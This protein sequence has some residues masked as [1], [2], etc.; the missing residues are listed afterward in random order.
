MRTISRLVL[1]WGLLTMPAVVQAVIYAYWDHGDGTCTITGY[2]GSGGDVRIPDMI[3]GLTVTSIGQESFA[4][5]TGLTSVTISNGVTS[6]GLRA[7]ESC[8]NLTAITVSASNPG[9][10]SLDGVL[11]NKKRSTLIQCPGGKTGSYTIPN[12]V[13]NIEGWAFYG[14]ISLTNVVIGNSVTNIGFE[15]FCTCPSLTSVTIGPKVTGIGGWAFL[16]CTALTRLT[17]PNSVISIGDG[18]FEYCTNLTAGYFQG[19]APSLNGSS[20]FTNAPTTI[21]YFPETTGWG[22]TFGGRPTVP[23]GYAYTNNGDGTCAITGYTGNGGDVTIPNTISNLLVT[24]IGNSAF[25]DCTNLTS[26]AIPDSVTN[27]G[28]KAFQYCTRLTNVVTGNNVSNI[29]DSAFD[30]CYSLTGVMIPNSVTNIGFDAFFNCTSLSNVTI[31]DRVISIYLGAF[32]WCTSLMDIDVATSNA[33]Y[34]SVDGVLFDKNLTRLIQYPIGRAGSFTFPSSVTSIE[35][36]A[37]GGSTNL[38]SFTIPDGITQIWPAAF[39]GCHNLVSVTIAAS[40]TEIHGWAFQYCQSL[41]AVYFQGNAPNVNDDAFFYD[42]NATFYYLPGT[43]GWDSMG[44]ISWGESIPIPIVLWNPRAQSDANFGVQ[45]NCFGFTIS[46]STNLVIVT[47]ACTNLA[48]PSWSA[49]GTNTLTGGSSYFS[50]P[51]WTNSPARFYR[52]RSP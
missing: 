1:L 40:V 32:S 22:A 31:P 33:R 8:T 2:L 50:D 13:T 17:I 36:G 45:T 39:A 26:V 34:C 51:G 10:S 29:G 12:S 28:N 42:V 5:K 23:L 46:G 19:N 9:Y 37:F 38:T 21:Y 48:N 4:Y 27:I 20:V 7:F 35:Y 25:S 14:C 43:T 49:L 30:S 44:W 41:A 15:A 3:D 18:A 11:F 6:I 47:E 24:S 16:D 52:F